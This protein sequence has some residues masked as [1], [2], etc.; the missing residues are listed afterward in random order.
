MQHG[1]RILACTEHS[2]EAQNTTFQEVD[3]CVC[4][5][6][7]RHG[8]MALIYGCDDNTPRQMFGHRQNSFI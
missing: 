1:R 2:D 7:T 3:E 6:A 5:E 4:D 8:E